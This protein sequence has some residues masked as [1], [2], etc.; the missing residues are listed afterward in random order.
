MSVGVAIMGWE[1]CN[2]LHGVNI[3][4][5]SQSRSENV[6]LK[7]L[8]GSRVI[9]CRRTPIEGHV[10]SFFF[11]VSICSMVNARIVPV[12]SILVDIFK[13]YSLFHNL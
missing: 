1:S 4:D 6:S 2:H 5:S 10:A 11:N 12:V 8:K 7:A 13:F 3:T 9:R